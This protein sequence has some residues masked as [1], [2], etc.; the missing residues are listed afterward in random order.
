MKGE[1]K[2]KVFSEQTWWQ[3]EAM[4]GFFSYPECAE[5]YP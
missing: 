1:G 3:K 5:S 4:I 2:K